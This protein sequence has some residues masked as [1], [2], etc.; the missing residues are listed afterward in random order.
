MSFF[1]GKKILLVSNKFQLSNQIKMLCLGS[2]LSFELIS[3]FYQQQ[4][5]H[6]F[7]GKASI[8]G[9]L[10]DFGTNSVLT[11]PQGNER[12]LTSQNANEV[13]ANL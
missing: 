1:H 2:T 7:L 11:A 3:A 5:S 10:S 8:D 4:V 12:G 6:D 13:M 9:L